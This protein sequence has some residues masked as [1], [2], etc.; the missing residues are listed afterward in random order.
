MSFSKYYG[1]KKFLA[2]K[3][4]FFVVGQIVAVR[5]KRSKHPNNSWFRARV[6]KI[7]HSDNIDKSKLIVSFKNKI[8]S[9]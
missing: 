9:I 8:K 2:E 7:K 4:T 5:S 3:S 1:N 6:C